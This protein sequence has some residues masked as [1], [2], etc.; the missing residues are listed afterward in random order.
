MK[1]EGSNGQKDEMNKVNKWFKKDY[2]E[3]ETIE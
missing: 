3:N 1:V 2:D